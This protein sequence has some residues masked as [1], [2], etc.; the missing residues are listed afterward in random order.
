M[1]L[2]SCGFCVEPTVFLSVEHADDGSISFK[3]D[4]GFAYPCRIRTLIDNVAIVAV[5]TTQPSQPVIRFADGA[6]V[7]SFS[8]ATKY[9]H[10]IV[11][12]VRKQGVWELTL[13]T[14]HIAHIGLVTLD[15]LNRSRFFG[16]GRKVLCA[17]QCHNVRAPIN[18]YETNKLIVGKMRCLFEGKWQPK[19][20]ESERKRK[21]S[22]EKDPLPQDDNE[23][24]ETP[25]VGDWSVR[26]PKETWTASLFQGYVFAN[27]SKAPIL[28]KITRI[29]HPIGPGNPR[30]EATFGHPQTNEDISLIV[31]SVTLHVVK[32][33]RATLLEA[34]R[35]D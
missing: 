29:Y 12:K 5:L 6:V 11:G 28:R 14:M 30:I 20:Q 35:C 9:A 15:R 7:R 19:M 18:R 26:H 32:Q 13:W 10:Q 21:R 17:M 1:V 27:P 25:S 3:G 16:S 31:S 24:E 8:D 23:E 22:K 33:Y 34:L 4:A 2:C